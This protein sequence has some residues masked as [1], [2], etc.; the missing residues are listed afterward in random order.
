M[1]PAAAIFWDFHTYH[2]YR[3]KTVASNPDNMIN[4]KGNS[5]NTRTDATH[6]QMPQSNKQMQ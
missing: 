5:C 2:L 6:K 3:A 4:Y 1:G